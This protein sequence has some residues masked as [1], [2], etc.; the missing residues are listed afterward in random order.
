LYSAFFSGGCVLHGG[1]YHQGGQD[2]DLSAAG[3]AGTYIYPSP[4]I[5]L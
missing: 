1:G 4:V 3:S 2:I 5:F